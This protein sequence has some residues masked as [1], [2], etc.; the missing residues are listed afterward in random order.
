MGVK[1]KTTTESKLNDSPGE[2]HFEGVIG[3][4]WGLKGVTI[5]IET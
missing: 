1:I 4:Q 3:G 2:T 5:I